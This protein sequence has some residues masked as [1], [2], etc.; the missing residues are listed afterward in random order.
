MLPLQ[1]IR[2]RRPSADDPTTLPIQSQSSTRTR[3]PGTARPVPR[4]AVQ[5]PQKGDISRLP[6]SARPATRVASHARRPQTATRPI[7]HSA[8]APSVP[9]KPAS[10]Y[11]RPRNPPP[12]R[13]SHTAPLLP[14]SEKKLAQNSLISQPRTNSEAEKWDI[15]PEGNSGGR[16][17]RRFA[18]SNVGNNGRIYLRYVYLRRQART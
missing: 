13:S 1:G 8:T 9:T 12:T 4:R 2:L 14:L 7:D 6:A 3:R 18:V 11:Q 15:A 16:E 5:P 10:A 17:G